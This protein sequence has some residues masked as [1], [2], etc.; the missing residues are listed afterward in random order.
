MLGYIAAF[1]TGAM[2][3]IRWIYFLRFSLIL[4]LFPLVLV[5]LN[6]L[7]QTLTSGILV[8]E[9]LQGYLCVA[10]FLV[11]SG[12][13]ALISARVTLINGPERWND[14]KDLP[15]KR[16]PTPLDWLMVNDKGEWEWLA[17]VVALLP[18][19]LTGFNL[20]S[21]GSTEW[22]SKI[23]IVGGL[24][25]GT[26][27]AGIVWYVVNVWYY[28]TY[29]APSY[30]TQKEANPDSKPKPASTVELGVNAA[31]TILY[32]RRWLFL[33]NP[34]GDPAP[35]KI[36]SAETFLSSKGMEGFA[37]WITAKFIALA[38]ERGYAYKS[39]KKLYEAQI[40]AILAMFVFL[41]QYLMIWPLAAPVP[42]LYMSIA[43]LAVLLVATILAT[44]VFWSA[45]PKPGLLRW[46]IGL[47]VCVFIFFFLV[48][49]LYLCS[50]AERF[51][52]FATVLIMA[53]SLFWTLAGA[54]F[55]VDRYRVPVITLLL[56]ATLVPR[57]FP[58]FFRIGSHE[59]HYFSTVSMDSG[60]AGPVRTPS[61]ILVNKLNA[62]GPDLPLI[63]VTATGGGLH[64]S[65]WTTAVLAKLETEFADNSDSKGIE[66]FHK[67]LL[68]LS[69][70]SGGSVGLNAYLH[71]LQAGTLDSAG[72]PGLEQMK[73]AAQCSSLEAVGWGLV[74][75]DLPR[76]LVPFVPQSS[77]EDDLDAYSTPLFK[78]RTWALRKG[79]ER[80]EE[81]V[82]CRAAW[83]FD[84]K[85]DENIEKKDAPLSHLF[86]HERSPF[87]LTLKDN[88]AA[89]K[90]NQQGK[91]PLTLRTFLDAGQNGIPAFTMN[92]TSVELGG[93]FLLANYQVPHYSLDETE[94][95]PAQSFLDAF[96]DPSCGAL[97]LPLATAAQLSAT[98]PYVSSAAR[99][100]Q[101]STNCHSVHF[102]D[103][104]YYDNDGTGSALEFLRYALAPPQ[105]LSSFI[106]DLDDKVNKDE[107]LKELPPCDARRIPQVIKQWVEQLC[108]ELPHLNEADKS[109]QN[110]GHP[111][112]V[113]WIEIRNSGDYDG[114]KDD[115][116]G[117]DGAK[118]DPAN[119][120]G[121][122]GAVP[123]GFWM[124]GH[125]SV[126]GRT[127]VA[128]G[129]ME[130]AFSSRIQ[131]HRIVL[132]DSNSKDATGTDPLNWSLTPRQRK[133]VRDSARKMADSYR[134]AK[135]WFYDKS[136]EHWN[137]AQSSSGMPSV[138]QVKAIVPGK[139]TELSVKQ[140]HPLRHLR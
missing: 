38:G 55:Y 41:G 33:T 80:N 81:N 30:D 52:I 40:F 12:F 39:G 121:Q 62:P 56:L 89:E 79:V 90:T 113:L 26:L 63:V 127:R 77:G 64:A 22:V 106:A 92:T 11:S 48:L 134:E 126:T 51:P 66:P 50:S 138:P 74:Y 31:R 95:Y 49:W 61:Q 24:L 25:G 88:L 103:G 132:A 73:A 111:L 36:E 82:Y 84:A 110:L 29:N 37:D 87:D 96:G 20:V 129:L 21:Y 42:S 5:G 57:I 94:V 32:P 114:G 93:R 43:V 135:D 118:P 59:E 71:E 53:I 69:T 124:A 3:L 1:L 117:G 7:N 98:F 125:E 137:I 15:E 76:S 104:G 65:A 13:A 46:K 107:K 10:F 6:K 112:R 17:I 16:Q 119:L 70:V 8:P 72:Q 101:P 136:A 67:H 34:G 58:N 120:L 83:K 108:D 105:R 78:D 60:K 27:L 14:C 99:A 109:I 91:T 102:V 85:N 86:G 75:Y 116:E 133:E 2:R 19:I 122:L 131:I 23:D 123:K 54:A 45:V 128:L 44:V 35:N 9:F 68:L 130:Q 28:F 100:P 139:N 97:D 115:S 4:W 47:T 18:A 140:V